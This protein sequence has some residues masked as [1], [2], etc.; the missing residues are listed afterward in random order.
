MSESAKSESRRKAA[1]PGQLWLRL[2]DLVRDALYETVIGA[3]LACVDE[4]LEAER[5]ALCGPRY[6]HAVDR[7]ALRAGHV[8]SSLVLGG[9]RVA[10]NRPRARSVEGRELRLPSWREW[11]AR[12]P[13][14]ERA[15]EQMVLGVSTRRYARSLEPLPEAVTVRGVS[16]S[17]VSERFVY[18]TERKLAELMSRE[19]RELHVVALLIDG[20]HFGE[21]MVLAAVGVDERG[22][23]HVLGL[24]EG[25]TENAAAVRALLAD[26]V[27]RGLATDRSLLIVIDGAKA[28][29]KAVVEVFGAHALIQRCREHKKRNV[30][31]ALPER[32]RAA[33]RSAMNQ[34]YATRDT[35]RARRL[36]DTLAR[37]LE[38]QHPGAAASLREGLEETLTV[39]R[40]GLSED[41]ERV[42]SSTNLIENLFSRVREI[43]RRVKRWQSG[44]MVLRW[45]AAGV[46][47]AERG[48]R[49]LVGYRAMPTLVVALRARD[50]QFERNPEIDVAEK[51]A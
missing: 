9:R 15:L 22:D 14:E 18:G 35:K 25:A 16:K 39:M 43:G 11:S 21:H 2:P 23:K 46:L 12:D 36:L 26:L 48:F 29:H 7:K 6:E 4:A 27:E 38:H 24:R 8:G 37:R 31:D 51:A 41:L 32:L 49:K 28:L 47:E 3:G 33:V 30:T 44:T 17:A 10:V 34:A 5:V 19:L 13:L 20:M 50:A 1:R 42:L 45:T 40:L